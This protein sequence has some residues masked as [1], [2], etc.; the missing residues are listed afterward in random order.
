[1]GKK[2]NVK[3]IEIDGR[4]TKVQSGDKVVF[5]KKIERVMAKPIKKKKA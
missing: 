1:M 4:G 2:K 3:I 5:R